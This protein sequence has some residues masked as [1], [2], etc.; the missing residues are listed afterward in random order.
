[1]S[2]ETFLEMGRFVAEHGPGCGHR[3]DLLPADGVGYYGDLDRRP[4]PWNGCAAGLASC[5]ITA[6]GL[7]KGCLSMPDRLVEGDLRHHDLWDIWF[8]ADAF[9]YNRSFRSDD[10]GDACAGCEHGLQC[11]GG[12]AVMSLAA[13]GGFHG[14]PYCFHG[15]EQRA[16]GRPQRLSTSTPCQ[17]PSPPRSQ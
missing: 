7:V 5:G 13:T 4:R 17:V 6:E 3:I 2:D 16:S 9:A 8:S 15:I 10:L 12:C 14:D 1:M 11:R